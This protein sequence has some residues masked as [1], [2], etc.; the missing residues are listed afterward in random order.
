MYG[1]RCHFIHDEKKLNQIPRSYYSYLLQTY[2]LE[3]QF[4]NNSI[5]YFNNP[6]MFSYVNLN[7]D[8]PPNTHESPDMSILKSKSSSS[9]NSVLSKET[10]DSNIYTKEKFGKQ[11]TRRLN[12]FNE[13]FKK[14]MYLRT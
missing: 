8:F 12:V 5:S 3:T 11:K 10:E 2:H 1:P 13:I 9:V 14:I 6:F 4:R 7:T